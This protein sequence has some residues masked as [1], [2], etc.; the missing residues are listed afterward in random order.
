V[1]VELN[2]VRVVEGSFASPQRCV[3]LAAE[4][5]ELLSRYE[6][7]FAS[8][9]FSER[10]FVIRNEF[11][12][13]GYGEPTPQGLEAVELLARTE[14]VTLETTY[15]AKA[16]SALI[17]DV[18]SGRIGTAPA[19]FWNTYNAIPLSHLAASVDYTHLPEPFHRF[20]LS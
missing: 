19:L 14:G 17:A 4:V 6:P 10:D 11:F 1:A 5:V 13:A 7:T 20:F 3:Q 16:C 18:R 8:L 2:L 12:G 15:S 9:H